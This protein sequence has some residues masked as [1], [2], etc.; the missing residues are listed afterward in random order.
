LLLGQ[1]FI[2]PPSDGQAAD[3][4]ASWLEKMHLSPA[5][6]EEDPK[7]L[8]VGEAQRIALARA[9]LLAPQVLLLDEP[10]SALDQISKEAIE[11]TLR[12]CAA[13]GIAI[14][15]VT[16]DPRQMAELAAHGLEL[17]QGEIKRRW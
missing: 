12:D 4:A 16:H 2:P 7:R 9:I 14:V 10:T 13:Q 11:K 3:L 8:S 17:T 6:L 5:L 1:E 15:L